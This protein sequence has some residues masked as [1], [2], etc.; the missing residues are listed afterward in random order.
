MIDMN[1]YNIGENMEIRTINT[2]LKVASIQNFSNAAEQLGYSQSAVTVQIQKLEKELQVQLF[3]RIGKRVYLTEKGKEFVSYANEIMKASQAALEFSKEENIISGTL[4]IG[5]VESECTALL[6]ELLPQFYR[7]C[8][9]VEVVIRSGTTDE[10]IYLAESNELDLVMTL[11]EKIYRSE[12]ICALEQKEEIVF[13]TLDNGV[14]ENRIPVEDLC[15]EPFLLTETGAAYRYELEQ[16]LAA[17]GLEIHP[18][19]EIGNTETIIKLLK[20][21][22][23]VSFLPRFTV[24][25]ELQSHTLQPISTDLPSVCMHHQLLYHKSK[26]I[27]KQMKVFMELAAEHFAG[28]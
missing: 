9:E 5:G 8:P 12:W 3:E 28:K 15:R 6:P 19:L 17:R 7:R 18:I 24:Q 27:T 4:R 16:Q 14:E 10:M 1:L 20:K 22:M 26:W 23:G 13:V 2:F 11:D 21:G 25:Q